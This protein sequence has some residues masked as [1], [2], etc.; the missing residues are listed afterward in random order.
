V[1]A[2]QK[3]STKEAVRSASSGR[4]TMTRTGAGP[5]RTFRVQFGQMKWNWLVRLSPAGSYARGRSRSEFAHDVA[6]HRVSV[7]IDRDHWPPRPR[8]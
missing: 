2:A 4:K 6:R 3:P 1:S 5:G 8:A 7:R